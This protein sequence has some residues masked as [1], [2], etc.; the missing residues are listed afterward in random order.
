VSSTFT[1]NTGIEKIG[2]GQQS[3]LWG[4]TTNLNFDIVDRALNGSI[5]IPLAGTTH[6]LVTSSGALSD[7]QFAVLVFTG[8]LGASNTVSITPQTA[9]KLYW[10]RN[11]TNQDVILSQGTGANVTVPAGTSKVVFTNGAGATAAVFDIT[12]TLAGNLTGNVTGNADT[13][14]ALQTA[15]TIG[16]VSFNGTANINLPGVNQAGT[17][18]TSGNAATATR[19]QTARTLTI[20]GV[21]QS[22]DGSSN[23]AWTL[24]TVSVSGGGTGRTT[25]SSGA[26]LLGAG[27]G[28]VGQLTGSSV[29]QIPQWNGATWAVSTLPPTGVQNVT[30]TSPLS[31]SG[32]ATPNISLTGTVP[33]NRGGTNATTVA[34]ARSNLGLGTMATQNSN[35]VSITG[36]TVLGRTSFGTMAG[37]NSNS[38]SITGGSIS[39][40][41]LS[42]AS[43]LSATTE[44]QANNVGSY[45]LLFDTVNRVTD[46]NGTRAGSEMRFASTYTKTEVPFE[47][48]GG[49]FFASGTWRCLGHS[50]ARNL[51][52][53][54][55]LSTRTSLWLRIA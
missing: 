44:A 11:A 2:D 8:S 12:N 3:G 46:P 27:T 43:V 25:L 10:V 26:L 52:T 9:Q 42:S 7:G 51:G 14:T 36:G 21:G 16:G 13:A 24:P 23:V 4:Q 40:V 22:V 1:T 49:N 47:G 20:N 34:A 35:N 53:Q 32:G 39:G 15:R 6:S 50:G 54:A 29:G 28:Q 30:A 18:N 48:G 41:S 5:Q 33:I 17:Q 45:A 55:L 19:W 38:V 37:Q 31:S